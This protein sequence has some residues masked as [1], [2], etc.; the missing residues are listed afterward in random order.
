MGYCTVDDVYALGLTQAALSRVAASLAQQIEA[1]S[2]EI[3][4]YLGAGSPP[5]FTP[6]ILAWG[7]DLRRACA[8]HV[9]YKALSTVGGNPASSVDASLRQQY[10]DVIDW[11]LRISSGAIKLVGVTDSAGPSVPGVPIVRGQ[12]DRGYRSWA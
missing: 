3:D 11:L 2:R 12:A 1:S 8:Q 5:K 7:E 9:A 10:E 6:P 4:G